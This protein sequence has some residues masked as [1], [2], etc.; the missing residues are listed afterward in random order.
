MG[1]LHVLQRNTVDHDA[2]CVWNSISRLL[3]LFI[4]NCLGDKHRQVTKQWCHTIILNKWTKKA[5]CATFQLG[6]NIYLHR[7]GSSLPISYWPSLLSACPWGTYFYL[8]FCCLYPRKI[9]GL[10]ILPSIFKVTYSPDASYVS[11]ICYKGWA[12]KKVL[13][14]VQ[15]FWERDKKGPLFWTF[16][17]ILVKKLGCKRVRI[18]LGF[19]FIAC[20]S[21]VLV[22]SI[23]VYEDS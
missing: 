13:E 4:R 20:F 7:F 19:L 2:C 1:K 5:T 16:C 3:A 17:N 10:H 11:M 22:H 15:I 6:H 18:S 9:F 8:K 23:M 12:E 14:R 21:P